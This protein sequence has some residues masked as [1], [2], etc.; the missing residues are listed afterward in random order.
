M[1]VKRWG[2]SVRIEISYMPTHF[3]VLL[4][5]GN[6]RAVFF[7]YSITVVLDQRRDTGPD[8]YSPNDITRKAFSLP[9]K[10][11]SILCCEGNTNAVV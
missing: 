9:N 6:V 4:E 10:P 5:R 1:Q 2:N 11:N 3:L 7:R 8:S